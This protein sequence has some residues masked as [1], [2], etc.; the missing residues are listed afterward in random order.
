[1]GAPNEIAG[2]KWRTDDDERQC[3]DQQQRF[4][5]EAANFHSRLA[6][7]LICNSGSIRG[8]GRALYV[9]RVDSRLPFSAN[10]A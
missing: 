6:H 4:A 1:M 7:Y 9:Q 10:G 5:D 8:D 3:D 2:G